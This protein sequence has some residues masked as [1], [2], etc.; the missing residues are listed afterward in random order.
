MFLDKRQKSFSEYLEKPATIRILLDI[1]KLYANKLADYKN[2]KKEIFKVVESCGLV[3]A[4]S[5]SLLRRRGV[6]HDSRRENH[7]K[8]GICRYPVGQ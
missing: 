8:T 7:R 6:V 3:D 5:V 1:H 4:L 2:D